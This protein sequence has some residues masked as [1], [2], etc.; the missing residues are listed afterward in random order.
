MNLGN[1]PAY[2]G[3][4]NIYKTIEDKYGNVIDYGDIVTCD[5]LLARKF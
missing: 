3:I 4:Y 5:V 1:I 2:Y